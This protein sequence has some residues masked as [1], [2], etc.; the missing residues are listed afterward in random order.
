MSDIFELG[1]LGKAAEQPWHRLRPETHTTR[2][3][4]HPRR[5][6]GVP[7]MD[8]RAKLGRV[9]GTLHFGVHSKYRLERGIC[10]P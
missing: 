4:A 8:A 10:G 5:C 7:R 6:L 3:L 9:L 2:G 1:A